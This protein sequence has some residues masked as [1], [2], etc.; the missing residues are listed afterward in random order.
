MKKRLCAAGILLSVLLS[1]L[2]VQA[3]SDFSH[4]YILNGENREAIGYSRDP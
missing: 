4:D 1:G 3:K 2:T